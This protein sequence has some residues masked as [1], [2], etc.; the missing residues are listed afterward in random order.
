MMKLQATL[1]EKAQDA[2]NIAR[3]RVHTMEIDDGAEEDD[4]ISISF[5]E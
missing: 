2:F 4:G 3:S 1:V 5:D